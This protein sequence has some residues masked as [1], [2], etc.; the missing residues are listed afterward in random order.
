MGA[1]Y[2]SSVTAQ[3][4]RT[5]T[6]SASFYSYANDAFNGAVGLSTLS[7]STV[8]SAGTPYTF[9]TQAIG[10][11][12]VTTY[13]SG[14]GSDSANLNSS[15]NGT[16][17]GTPTYSQLTVGTST[18][19]VNT[20]I[21][22]ASLAIVAVPSNVSATGSGTDTANLDD[23]TG[24]NALVAEGNVATLTTSIDTLSVKNFKTVNA[25][26][27]HRQQRHDSSVGLRRR[28]QLERQLDQ[29]LKRVTRYS[30]AA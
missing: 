24:S 11:L 25:F 7:G 8:D 18:I 14:S 12:S 17:T 30:S 22:S 23:A 6:G 29:R 1:L 5:G 16:F 10:F 28:T 26:Q 13:E 19:T 3:A 15:G 9:Q 21:V 2:F 27:I 4:P 20:F